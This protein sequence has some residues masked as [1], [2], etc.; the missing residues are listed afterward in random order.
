MLF[1][2]E[3]RPSDMLLLELHCGTIHSVLTRLLSDGGRMLSG[4]Y[5]IIY[6]PTLFRTKQNR[7]A[8]RRLEQKGK[9]QKLPRK[10]TWWLLKVILLLNVMYPES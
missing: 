4:Q 3:Q 9:K 5:L 7:E 2:A 8:K 10:Q 1:S 6:R